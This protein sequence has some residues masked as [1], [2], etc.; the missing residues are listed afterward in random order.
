M[1][2]PRRLL[3]HSIEWEKYQGTDPRTRAPQYA[4]TVQVGFV[5][6]EE[7]K[8]TALG[9]LGEQQ[10]DRYKLFYDFAT[11]SPAGLEFGSMDRVTYSGEQFIVRKVETYHTMGTSAPHHAEIYLAG[12]K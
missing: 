9:N 4:D 8:E 12:T 3:V 1:H 2:I 11:S 6:L 10:N 7:V 5:R